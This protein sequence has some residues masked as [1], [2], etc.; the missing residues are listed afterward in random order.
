MTGGP[1]VMA[2]E[3]TIRRGGYYIRL[4]WR[5]RVSSTAVCNKIV[6]FLSKITDIDK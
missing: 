4:P 2:L 3:G 6:V 1:E 5:L